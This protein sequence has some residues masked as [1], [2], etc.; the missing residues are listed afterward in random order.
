M[1]GASQS[2]FLSRMNAQSSRIVDSIYL[3]S[4]RIAAP[5]AVAPTAVAA[6]ASL[7]LWPAGGGQ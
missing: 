6:D 7:N 4:T 5:S 1:M 3:I 2:F